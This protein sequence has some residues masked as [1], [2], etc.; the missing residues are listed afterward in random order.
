MVCA[1][2]VM[3]L[4][5]SSEPRP[6]EISPERFINLK[7]SGPMARMARILKEEPYLRNGN[8]FGG[9]VIELTEDTI[10]VRS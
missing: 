9:K 2:I 10:T 8:L 5:V 3:A 7:G 1:L 6:T 4:S